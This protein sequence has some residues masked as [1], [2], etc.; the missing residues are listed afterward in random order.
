LRRRGG[1]GKE[2]KKSG[3]IKASGQ[4]SPKNRKQMCSEER[5]RE[6]EGDRRRERGYRVGKS[7]PRQA[8]CIS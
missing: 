2:R 3:K 6:K 1:G 5:E 4:K 8:L 7:T